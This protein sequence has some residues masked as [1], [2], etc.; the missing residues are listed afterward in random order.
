[1]I[2]TIKNV[3]YNLKNCPLIGDRG[4]LFADYKVDLFTYFNIYLFRPMQKNQLGFVSFSKVKSKIRKR[5][6]TYSSQ[7]HSQ[8][9]W[10]TNNAKSFLAIPN[11]LFSKTNFF[12]ITKCLNVFVFNILNK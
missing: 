4:N 8:F 2:L 5:I 3:K 1:M 11:R 10:Y 12:T 6:E 9:F 7:L